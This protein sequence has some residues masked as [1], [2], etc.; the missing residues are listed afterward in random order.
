MKACFVRERCDR[1]LFRQSAIHASGEVLAGFRHVDAGLDMKRRNRGSTV[2]GI[3][4]NVR[5]A[6]DCV[7]GAGFRFGD[8]KTEGGEGRGLGFGESREHAFD[9]ACPSG[10][11][12]SVGSRAALPLRV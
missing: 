9:L 7:E 5:L 1:F 11:I 8:A 6:G 12:I 4:Q 10:A 2:S 3:P